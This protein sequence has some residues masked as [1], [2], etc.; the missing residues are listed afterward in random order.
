MKKNSLTTRDLINKYQE[1]CDRI[2][3]LAEVCE[4]EQRQRTD[5]EESEY[6][7]LVR[8]NQVLQMRFQVMNA[9]KINPV[10]VDYDKELRRCMT[11]MRQ[12]KG[13]LTR[14]ADAI[15]TT[16]VEG[17]GIIAIHEQEML[18]PIRE[19]LIWNRV[20]LNV[21]SGLS[22]TLRWP[23]HGKA[24]AQW[25]GEGARLTDSKI[26]FSKLETKPERCGI[27]IPITKETLDNSDGIVEGVIREEMPAAVIDKIND[28][29]FCTD[30]S[31]RKVWGPFAE[32]G[33]QTFKFAGEVPTRKELLKMK[34][35]VA[36]SGLKMT[37]P[38]WVITEAM[39]AEL[40]DLP[41]DAGSG[42]FVCENDR[43][44]G[45]PIFTTPVIGE[46]KIG[47][48]DWSYQAAGFFNKWDFTVDPYTL[49]RNHEVDFVLNIAFATVCLYKEAFILG[50]T[51]TA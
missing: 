30:K 13:V 5:A 34:A 10:K 51:K 38:C 9:P 8:E 4:K 41:V 23:K 48:G 25:V 6:V 47:F 7:A 26:D 40:E 36:G 20:G 14:D 32:D 1:N 3:A 28:A 21:R 11:E 15:M 18:K 19:G 33:A 2:S 39:K 16:D 45:Y 17:T 29:L 24:T 37:N 44:L 42:R 50:S 46:G 22:G 27:A 49:A 12:F 31:G 35:K 43:I